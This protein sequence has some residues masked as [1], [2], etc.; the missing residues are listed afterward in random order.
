[1]IDR[2]SLGNFLSKGSLYAKLIRDSE[3]LAGNRTVLDLESKKNARGPETN[4]NL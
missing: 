3:E 2:N 4:V 1:M